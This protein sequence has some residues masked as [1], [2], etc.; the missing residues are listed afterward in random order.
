MKISTKIELI[1]LSLAILVW[2][3]FLLNTR[4]QVPLQEIDQ[5]IESGI[6]VHKEMEIDPIKN[7]ELEGDFNLVYTNDIPI[8]KLEMDSALIDHFNYEMKENGTL[9]IHTL[10]YLIKDQAK[11][12]IY[13]SSNQLQQIKLSGNAMFT[14]KDTLK[15]NILEVYAR[16][17]ARIETVVDVDSLFVN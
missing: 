11:S 15:S 17:I 2:I 4:F 6:L 8:L 10:P 3:Y 9:I 14:S 1:F 12:T 7:I 5:L 13:L 16:G